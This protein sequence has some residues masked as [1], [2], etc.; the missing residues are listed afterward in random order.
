MG[1]RMAGPGFPHQSQ[2]TTPH[3]APIFI[4]G[5]SET[6][7]TSHLLLSFLMDDTSPGGRTQ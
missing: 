4:V 5:A 3:R 1:L 7:L 6:A 2:H